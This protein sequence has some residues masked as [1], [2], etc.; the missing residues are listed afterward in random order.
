MSR[1]DREARFV[2]I[3]SLYAY[4]ADILDSISI[5]KLMCAKNILRSTPLAAI[6][7]KG[8]GSEEVIPINERVLGVFLNP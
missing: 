4:P 6:Y 7:H 1:V 2:C 5:S 8:T 3:C